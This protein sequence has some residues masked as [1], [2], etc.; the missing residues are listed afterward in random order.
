[1][2][3]AATAFSN[4]YLNGAFGS[5]GRTLN[6]NSDL[7]YEVGCM[8]HVWAFT[9]YDR[10][11][12]PTGSN[13]AAAGF[14]W[15]TH[16]AAPL[17]AAARMLLEK[18]PSNLTQLSLDRARDHPEIKNVPVKKWI[19]FETDGYPEETMG[20]NSTSYTPNYKDSILASNNTSLDSSTEPSAP[21]DTAQACQNLVDV[22]TDAKKAGNDVGI[23][24]IAYGNARTKQCGGSNTPYVRDVMAKAAS[25]APNGSAS[26]A[27]KCDTPTSIT[28]ENSD[29][30]YFFCASTAADLQEVFKTA[31]GMTSS[32]VTKFVMPPS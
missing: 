21:N 22:A 13:P 32:P 24:M 14:P 26:T 29:G 31:I 23:I 15:G 3:P 17:K 6:S 25:N 7:V 12:N 20:L 10:N 18:E 11:G 2:L 19:I 30:D 5:K 28:A 27:S 9:G 4:D 8:D 16:L 1:M